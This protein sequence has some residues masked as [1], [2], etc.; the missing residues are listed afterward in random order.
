MYISTGNDDDGGGSG[1]GSGGGD[2]GDISDNYLALRYPCA[3]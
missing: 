3:V 1:G 2:D